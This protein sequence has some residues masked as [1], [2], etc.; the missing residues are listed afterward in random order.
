MKPHQQH[1]SPKQ[2]TEMLAAPKM[3]QEKRRLERAMIYMEKKKMAQDI[4]IFSVAISFWT[5]GVAPGNNFSRVY[6]SLQRAAG[7]PGAH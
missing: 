5:S 7:Y 6:S 4:M 2:F 3:T 1:P